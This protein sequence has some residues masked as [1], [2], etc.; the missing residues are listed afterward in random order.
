MCIAPNTLADGTITACH[1]C[2]Q[3]IEQAVND[4]VGRN[5]AETKTSVQS[6]AV[7]LTYG[8]DDGGRPDHE[9]STI[10][11]YSDVKNM[12]KKLRNH[13]YPVRYFVT[14]EYGTK[15]GRAH[16][17]IIFHW[18][19]RVPEVV[20]DQI[21]HFEHW[22]HG[23]TKWKP[24][25]PETIRYN[26]KY[27]LKDYADDSGQTALPRM[28]KKPPL[29]HEYFM[30]LADRHV[31]EAVAPQSAEYRFRGVTRRR[32][33]GGYEEIPFRM[34]NR[35]L[36]NFMQRFIEQWQAQRPGENLPQ[37]Q[38]VQ[39][40]LTPELKEER[41]ILRRNADLPVGSARS[42]A[43]RLQLQKDAD[44]LQLLREGRERDAWFASNTE[45]VVRPKT[46]WLGPTT[47]SEFYAEQEYWENYGKQK[48]QHRA[49]VIEFIEYKN[50]EIFREGG[51]GED[52]IAFIGPEGVPV[53]VKQQVDSPQFWQEF[54]KGG[55]RFA[56]GDV[57]RSDI[58][59]D[60]NKI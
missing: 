39:E 54:D 60:K 38:F 7:T 8:R 42:V 13:G 59:R 25:H 56:G 26:C 40:W 14:G 27:I 3:C 28:S 33:D 57:P 15:K 41:G 34:T 31:A 43:Q 23:H 17:H 20:L 9:R 35:T 32:R 1:K 50:G 10:L 48:S 36:E 19:E 46:P 16:W 24:V 37:S 6:H 30:Q 44:R 22:E 5:I 51:G 58:G 55:S 21:F 45:P 4:W 2:W 18:Q 29:G 11:T 52:R 12:L 47:L 53:T 49:H